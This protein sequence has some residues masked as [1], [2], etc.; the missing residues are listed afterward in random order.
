MTQVSILIPIYNG[1][2]FLSECLSSIIN[3]TFEDWEA[4]IG[5]N[6][7]TPD[8]NFVSSVNNLIKSL[9]NNKIKVIHYSNKP[10]KPKTLN[11]MI[12]DCSSN[13][14]AIL[15][16]DDVWHPQK[17][18]IQL[19]LLQNYDVVGTSCKYFG[20]ANHSPTLPFGN[21]KN[22][23]FLKYNPIINSSVILKKSDAVW[24]ENTILEDYE[25]WLNLF[26]LQKKSFYN[27]DKI[28]CFHRIHTQSSFNNINHLYVDELKNKWKT[29]INS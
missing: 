11:L 21:L 16:V 15:D 23:D 25:L 28:L 8:S 24:N 27:I 9:N 12:N 19:P 6:G 14:I 26:Y 4:I 17:L 5:I 22:F 18:E 1:S 20:H 13:L 7:H 10:N 2:E 3:Q 29:I